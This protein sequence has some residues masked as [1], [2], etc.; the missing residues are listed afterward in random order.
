MITKLHDLATYELTG[1][2]AINPLLANRQEVVFGIENYISSNENKLHLLTDPM[3]KIGLSPT[4]PTV[5]DYTRSDID[6]YHIFHNNYNYLPFSFENKETIWDDIRKNT[7]NIK[8]S[9]ALI[10]VLMKLKTT[11]EWKAISW[12]QYHA[13]ISGIVMP[14]P[15]QFTRSLQYR[16]LDWFPRW[17]EKPLP[18]EESLLKL[19]Q[20]GY[21]V[22]IRLLVQGD[23]KTR[24][25][26]A[27]KVVRS[28]N[29][30]RYANGW[31]LAFV[32]NKRQFISDMQSRLFKKN[33][34]ILCVS[35][36]SMFFGGIEVLQNTLKESLKSAKE[37]QEYLKDVSNNVSNSLKDISNVKSDSKEAVKEAV[38]REIVDEL[39]RAF[40]EAGLIDKEQAIEVNGIKTGA[41]LIIVDMIKPQ[42]HMFSAI[43]GKETDLE[44]S[45]G[46]NGLSIQKGNG[47]GSIIVTYPRKERQVVEL[48]DLLMSKEFIEFA[49]KSELPLIMGEDIFGRP[50]FYDFVNLVHMMISGTTGGGKSTFL[51]QLLLTLLYQ[52]SPELLT[53]H[54]IDTKK[55]ELSPFK[56][57]PHVAKPVI[58][59]PSVALEKLNE[60]ATLMDERYDELEK[61]GLKNILEHNKKHPDNRWKYQL[62]VIEEFADLKLLSDGDEQS[63]ELDKIVS[64]LNGKGR[65]SGVHIIMATQRPQHTIVS[66]L[67][68]ENMP[69][70]VTFF[71]SG[72]G[73]NTVF[74]DQV[75]M[76]FRLLDKGDGCMYW[77]GNSVE[78]LRFQSPI[79]LPD[80]KKI[81]SGEE[82]DL[83][84]AIID[85][86]SNQPEVS[87]DEDQLMIQ[88]KTI[89]ATTQETRVEE[90][91]KALHVRKD[92]VNKMLKKLV[93]EGWL[94]APTSTKGGYKLIASPEALESFQNCVDN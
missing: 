17:F 76:P 87:T 67:I 85:K 6:C 93:D 54:M 8:G 29:I 14:S 56:N 51:V 12:E 31:D 74:G 72:Y 30:S 89:I 70:K 55:V 44:I 41:T 59:E 88:L 2:K 73:Y 33:N 45:L 39:T 38:D 5:I 3:N 64:R 36:L 42:R 61:E 66:G 80:E 40:Q 47:K 24:T 34:Q 18:I 27:D 23:L 52:V 1:F 77:M 19:E 43:K 32:R 25:K 26:L 46:I 90:L 49:E 60:M 48:R 20:D 86:W 75:K 82:I 71:L 37:T 65:A 69:T 58:F 63:K 16:I 91:R 4:R 79:Y 13:Y 57:M 84:K 21:M 83:Y 22:T 11:N 10:Q 9:S 68:K 53:F 15:V 62:I 35:E 92:L 7:K 28:F 94:E 81:D 50:L 78:F